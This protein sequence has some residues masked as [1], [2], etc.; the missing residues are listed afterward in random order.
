MYMAAAL[1]PPKGM[2]SWPLGQKFN[3]LVESLMTNIT[4][5]LVF[6]IYKA[7]DKRFYWFYTFSLYM[8]LLAPHYG[9][10]FWAKGHE[11]HNLRFYYNLK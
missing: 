9:L 10:N 11:F 2:D 8:V 3:I 1:H 5:H 7:E 4:M 6:Q